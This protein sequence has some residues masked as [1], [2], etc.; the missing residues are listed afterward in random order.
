MKLA[1]VVSFS[2]GGAKR[3]AR[4]AAGVTLA[5]VVFGALRGA[6]AERG[7]AHEVA[8]GGETSPTSKNDEILL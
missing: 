2:S 3:G 6:P 8:A 1:F 7:A 5:V 4:A